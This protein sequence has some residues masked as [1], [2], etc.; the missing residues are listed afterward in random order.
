MSK[1]SPSKI[2][3]PVD[4]SDT[5]INALSYAAN[6]A[7]KNQA[8]L[9][10]LHNIES[11][12]LSSPSGPGSYYDF[13]NVNGEAY[14]KDMAE[15]ATVHLKKLAEKTA[16]ENSITVESIITSGVVK[17]QIIATAQKN[18]VDLIVMGTHGSKGFVEFFIG[19][20]TI[21][22]I[23]EAKLPVLTVNNKTKVEG[24]SKIL[25][26]FRDE[27][28]SREKVDYA[29]EMAKMYGAELHILGIDTENDKSS[30]QKLQ[31]QAEQIKRFADKKNIKST[32]TVL[33]EG[34]VPE[35]ILNHAKTINADL[36]VVMAT[37]DKVGVS[38]FF[39]GSFCEQIVKHATIPVL[40]IYPHFNPDGA[41]IYVPGFDWEA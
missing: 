35:I 41:Q 40:S 7:V 1:I 11:T 4:F 2:L 15:K 3:V 32:I 20:N 30:S 8:T 34:Y 27:Y 31:L 13:T 37:L 33:V 9:Y 38:E 19:S 12:V 17:E 23:A 26:P 24:F 14:E 22:V 10:L 18:K 39:K 29:L 6:I 25:L 36:I 5:S 16:A 21:R 28:H